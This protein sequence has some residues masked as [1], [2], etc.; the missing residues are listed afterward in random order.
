M[1]YTLLKFFGWGIL[2]ACI[3]VCVGWALRSLKCRTELARAAGSTVDAGELER[4]RGRLADLEPV[5]AERDRLRI[6]LADVRH[7]DS[8]GIVGGEIP[9]A[10]EPDQRSDEESEAHPDSAEV[11]EPVAAPAHGE[12]A[13]SHD[14]TSAV[15]GEGPG[16]ES[17]DVEHSPQGADGAADLDGRDIPGSAGG[18]TGPDDVAGGEEPRPLD[19]DTAARVLGRKVTLDDL[20]V[21]EGIGPKICELCS[22]IGITTWRTL[23]DT[24]VADLQ[25][26]LDAAGSRY[27]VHKPATWP[28]QAGLLADGRWEEFTTVTDDLGGGT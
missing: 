3:G 20:T 21:I 11:T 12:T 15:T 28:L 26:M 16:G 8:P 9:D 6:Q 14:D 7:A 24:D 4:L 18:P 25:S 1:L 5:V 17:D 22:G 2:L 13:S 10:P 27:A 23:A 19:L